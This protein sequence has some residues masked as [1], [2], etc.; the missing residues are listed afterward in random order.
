MQRLVAQ[1][2]EVCEA[3]A[4][5]DAFVQMRP[6]TVTHGDTSCLSWVEQEGEV[7]SSDFLWEKR[8]P[9]QA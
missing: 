8:P 1:G 4:P 5:V 3:A 9:Y 7:R 2:L 6:G